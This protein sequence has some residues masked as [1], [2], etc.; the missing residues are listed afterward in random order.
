MEH[1]QQTAADRSAERKE[2]E[3]PDRSAPKP[4][5]ADVVAPAEAK[6]AEAK[7]A[8]AK[9]EA[10]RIKARD[11]KSLASVE[12]SASRA[13]VKEGDKND[14]TPA[15]ITV[16]FTGDPRGKADPERPEYAGKSFP[17]GKAVVVEDVPWIKTNL[18]NLRHNNHF[19]VE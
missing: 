3:R 7:E 2:A 18:D 10:D 9:A 16:T 15:K 19:R 14:K 4:P 8:A 12:T 17:K 13:A 5:T 11:D 1:K 6:A